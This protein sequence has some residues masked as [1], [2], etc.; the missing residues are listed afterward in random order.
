MEFDQVLLVKDDDKI[1]TQFT[2]AIY[3]SK[4][5]INLQKSLDEIGASD[6]LIET[7]G[8]PSPPKDSQAAAVAA[9]MGGGE[10]VSVGE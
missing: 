4:H 7:V 3:D 6:L 10:E 1:L 5:R 8:T 2:I 9:I